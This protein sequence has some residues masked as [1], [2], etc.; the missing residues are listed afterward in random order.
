LPIDLATGATVGAIIGTLI[1]PDIDHHATTQEEARF[2][3]WFGWFG[4]GLWELFWRGYAATY[5]H[6]G[7]SHA[8]ITGTLGR[9]AYVAIRL[10]P[11]I[12]L[13]LYQLWPLWLSW[14]PALLTVFAFNVLQD[15]V[16]LVLDGWYFHPKG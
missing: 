1:T 5:S 14:F 12:I 3:R 11:I 6:R 4:G 8:P 7:R 15:V 2:Y 16:H 10:S 13:A 9:W